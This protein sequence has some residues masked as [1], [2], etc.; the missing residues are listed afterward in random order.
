MNNPTAHDKNFARTIRERNALGMRGIRARNGSGA[1]SVSSGDFWARVKG[2]ARGTNQP[3]PQFV[4]FAEDGEVF[5]FLSPSERKQRGTDSNYLGLESGELRTVSG[6]RRAVLMVQ[7]CAAKPDYAQQ[8]GVRYTPGAPIPAEYRQPSEP[9]DNDIFKQFAALC[10]SHSLQWESGENPDELGIRD[11]D[12]AH[13]TGWF[14]VIGDGDGMERAFSPLPSF[15]R[16][17]EIPLAGFE[18]RGMGSAK[19]TPSAKQKEIKARRAGIDRAAD[20]RISAIVRGKRKDIIP[21]TDIADKNIRAALLALGFKE[22]ELQPDTETGELPV[23]YSLCILGMRSTGERQL[24]IL[25]A[26]HSRNLQLLHSPDMIIAD[27]VDPRIDSA[28]EQTAKQCEENTKNRAIVE[29]TRE[30]EQHHIREVAMKNAP[31]IQAQLQSERDEKESREW[32]REEWE[33]FYLFPIPPESKIES[34]HISGNNPYPLNTSR[35][36]DGSPIR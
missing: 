14:A 24:R 30:V 32:F 20:N 1:G 16:R 9:T 26:L 28:R 19:I 29:F 18:P 25:A 33:P 4:Q 27:G 34:G 8:R 3:Y 36:S 22:S 23:W 6:S 12:R 35:Y 2:K 15:V 11:Y 13:S 7:L 5:R 31:A 21:P 17:V 10:R